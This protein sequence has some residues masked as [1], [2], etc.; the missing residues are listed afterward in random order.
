MNLANRVIVLFV[1]YALISPLS[2]IAQSIS[3]AHIEDNVPDEKVFKKFLARDI[4][5]YFSTKWNK[6]IQIEYE[7]LRD[8]PTQSGVAYPKYYL[9]VKILDGS[10]IIEEA[11]VRIAAINKVRFEIIEHVSKGEIIRDPKKIETIFPAV[12]CDDIRS[13]AGAK[14]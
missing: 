12:L 10:T 1:L 3:D 5:K 8:A 4:Q 2:V 13:R 11:A 9:W 14:P 6:T 7:L